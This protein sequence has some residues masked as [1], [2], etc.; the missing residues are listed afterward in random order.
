MN[1]QIHQANK[2]DLTWINQSYDQVGFINSNIENELIVIA[3]VLNQKAG[4]GRLVNI[5]QGIGELGGI[6]TFSQFRKMGVAQ[7]IV[8][9]L[10]DKNEY[11][12]LYCLPFEPLKDFYTQFGFKE[13]TEDSFYLVPEKIK[14]KLA[15]CKESYPQKTLLLKLS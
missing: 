9:Y 3:T 10:I 2:D 14:T 11:T 15:W 6:Y 8:Q 1:I 5:L 13:V 4:L 12:T 7:K